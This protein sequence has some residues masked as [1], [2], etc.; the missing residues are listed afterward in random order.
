HDSTTNTRNNK[1]TSRSVD[2]LATTASTKARKFDRHIYSC[3]PTTYSIYGLTLLEHLQ[4]QPVNFLMHP[5]LSS[6][7][8][9]NRVRTAP[10]TA[11]GPRWMASAVQTSWSGRMQEVCRSALEMPLHE[12]MM[13]LQ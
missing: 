11:T 9:K 7:C 10:R 6:V 1:N 2:H 8:G 3:L 4:W 5:C 12:A 13:K